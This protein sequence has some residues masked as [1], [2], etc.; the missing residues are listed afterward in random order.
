MEPV[1][2]S[3]CENWTSE[4]LC[5]QSIWNSEFTQSW[6]LVNTPT[7]NNMWYMGRGHFVGKG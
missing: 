4:W 6:P 1:S 2:L 7:N 3:D 5:P